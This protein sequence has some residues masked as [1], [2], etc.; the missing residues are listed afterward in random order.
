MVIH[1]YPLEVG[2]KVSIQLPAKARVVKAGMQG[3]QPHIWVLK[4][5]VTF[6]PVIRTFEV[7]GTGW[8][9]P[10]DGVYIDTVFQ[11]AYVWHVF[12]VP[13]PSI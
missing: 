3:G 13:N 8:P 5:P 7:F 11:G 4:E 6:V 12:E 10:A 1:K 9:V 2:T